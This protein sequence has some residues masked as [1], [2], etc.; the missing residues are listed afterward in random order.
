M[1]CWQ[2]TCVLTNTPI[3]EDEKCVMFVFSKDA[4]PGGDDFQ[5]LMECLLYF[6]EGKYDD[7]GSV[8]GT[9]QKYRGNF[10]SDDKIKKVFVSREVVEKL[11][12][13]WSISEHISRFTKI[14]GYAPF[15][16]LYP[17]VI[18][19][20]EDQ[21]ELLLRLFLLLS[22]TRRSIFGTMGTG[23]Q[24]GIEEEYETVM[25][26]TNARITTWKKLTKA[27]EDED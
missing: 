27:D 9:P 4:R 2:E 1:G 20:K 10:H 13:K 16:E 15:K 11:R 25:K 17:N 19:H 21:Y 3:L 5:H 6:K 24:H 18:V 14:L 22:S 7:Y 12:E 8:K 26:L 23:C